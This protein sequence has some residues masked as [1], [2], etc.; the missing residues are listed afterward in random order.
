MNMEENDKRK[1]ALLALLEK[2]TN[3][4]DRTKVNIILQ[5]IEEL[6]NSK[7]MNK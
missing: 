1:L 2:Y 4:G 7:S 5:K 3:L 6:D